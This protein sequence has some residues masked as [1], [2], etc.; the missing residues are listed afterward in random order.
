MEILP[1]RAPSSMKNS[2]TKLPN[3][4]HFLHY[5]ALDKSVLKPKAFHVFQ[6]QSKNMKPRFSPVIIVFG[7]ALT[8]CLAED[9]TTLDGQKYPDVRDVALK[10]DG[11]FFV[12][13]AGD[14]LKGVTVPFSNLPDTIK[15]KY[16]CDPFEIGMTFARQN[17]IVNLNKN[18]AYS[19]DNL[20]AAKKKAQA[21]KKMLGFIMEW[22]SMLVPAHPMKRGSQ[23][24]LAHFYDV[25]KDGLVLV[26]V[27]HENELG[28]VPAAASRGLSGP[29]EG[30]FAPNMAVVTADCSQFVCEI[31][32][33]GKDSDGQIREQIF[34]E[35]IAVIRKF[36]KER[37]ASK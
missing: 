25:F 2:G 17:Q 13:G 14:S 4:K 35:K 29:E 7:C 23:S 15:E 10:N 18:L 24:G 31:P 33:G 32:F 19:L 11:L 22:D 27:R 9:I 3:M 1:T 20:E 26:F 36:A 16:H 37:D 30:G 5:F 6:T 21:E 12:T 8:A 34:R 28:K